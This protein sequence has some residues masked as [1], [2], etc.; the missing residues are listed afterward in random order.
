MRFENA[1][2]KIENSVFKMRKNVTK[3]ETYE[4]CEK[5]NKRQ[6]KSSCFLAPSF[7]LFSRYSFL[8]RFS[9]KTKMLNYKII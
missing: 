9:L 7:P 5:W 1:F 2:E 4:T 6:L 3:C 8:L